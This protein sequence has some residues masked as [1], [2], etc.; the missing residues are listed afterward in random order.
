[1]GLV[2]VGHPFRQTGTLAFDQV[3]QWERQVYDLGE[4]GNKTLTRSQRSHKRDSLFA[5]AE[6]GSVVGQ[7]RHAFQRYP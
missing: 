6:G 5:I 3:M 2:V 1:M 4:G 7:W